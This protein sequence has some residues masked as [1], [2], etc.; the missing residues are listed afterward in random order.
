MDD[1]ISILLNALEDEIYPF[2]G[3]EYFL[4]LQEEDRAAAALRATLSDAQSSLFDSYESAR[5][6]TAG[7]YQDAVARRAFL[8]AREVYR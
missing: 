6:A 8:L 5:N 4:S 1:Y 3:K 7:A 2:L